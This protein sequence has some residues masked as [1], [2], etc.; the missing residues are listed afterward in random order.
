MQPGRLLRQVRGRLRKETRQGYIL[1]CMALWS[2]ISFLLVSNFLFCAVTVRGRSMEPTLFGGD[3]FLLNRW[4]YRLFPL[5][6]GDLVVIRDPTNGELLV[7]R[8]V[9]LP[10][11]TIEIRREGLY[12]NSRKFAQHPLTLNDHEFFVMGDNRLVSLDSRA[13]GPIQFRDILGTISR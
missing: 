1:L 12:L 6:Y 5:T 3:Q 4:A 2:I 8:I 10:K 11:D 7:K 9:A 13:Y